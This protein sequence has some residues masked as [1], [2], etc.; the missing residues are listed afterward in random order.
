MGPGKKAIEKESLDAIIIADSF[1]PPPVV[2][3]SSNAFTT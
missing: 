1:T 2:P 3:R